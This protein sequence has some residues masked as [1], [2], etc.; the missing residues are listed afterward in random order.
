MDSDAAFGQRGLRKA[1]IGNMRSQVRAAFLAVREGFSP[2][3][4]IADPTL[5][6]RFIDACRDAGLKCPSPDLNR[7]LLNLRKAK[8]LCG[9]HSR[10]TVFREQDDYLFASEVSVRFLERR[11]QTTVDRIICAPDLA[12]ELDSLAGRLA[13]G[14]SSLQY[15]WAAL[16]LRKARRISPEP[17]SLAVR[18][19][20]VEQFAVDG[21][22]SNTVPGRQ[23]LYVFF[24][25]RETLYVGE[26]KNLRRRIEKHLDH[27]DNK[28]L[29]RWLW[30]H[31]ARDL[32]LEFHVLP[33]ETPT[34]VRKA[35]EIE[36]IRSRQPVF[37]SMYMTRRHKES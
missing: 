36:F 7:C 12:T 3:R 1:G 8:M 13:P 29:A 21:L 18:A 19:E 2:D 30:E 24:D 16:Y 15:R 5:D 23:G 27:S 11:D 25:S 4:V 14:R 35:L 37:N 34:R 26:A 6:Q 28:G 9:L 17:C 22:R 20:R 32:H 33:E 31:G 10:R